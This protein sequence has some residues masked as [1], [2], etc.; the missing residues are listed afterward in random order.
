M[1][2]PAHTFKPSR[3]NA[4]SS[5][6]RFIAVLAAGIPLALVSGCSHIP[7]A[8]SAVGTLA[9]SGRIQGGQQPVTSANIQ[10]YAVG[11]TGDG[12]AATAMLKT[13]VKSDSGGNFSITSDYTC[14][15]SSQQV[16]LVVTGGNPGLSAGTNNAALAMMAGLGSCGSLS[17]STFILVDEVTTVGSIAALYPYMTSYAAVG[18]ATGDA[19]SLTAAFS[20][21]NEFTNIAVGTAP[22][23]ALP[24]GYYASSTE[25]NTLADIVASCIN[26]AGGKA[27]DNSACGNLFTLT[28]PT[29]GAAPTDTVQAILN[30]LNNPTANVTAIFN[31]GGAY[32]P[33]LPDLASAPSNWS[34]PIL[35]IPAVPTFTPMAGTYVGT[36]TV[37]INEPT[38]GATVYYTTNGS[39]PTTSSTVYTGPITVAASET[40]KAFANEGGRIS[41]GVGTAAYV[42]TAPPPAATP[43]FSPAGGAYSAA[44]TVTI[45]DA[46]TGAFIYYTTDGSIPT[47]SSPYYTG[48][49]TVY[50]T[51]T[52]QAIAVAANY[53]ASAIGS[54]SYTISLPYGL[55][56]TFA[57]TGVLG[58]NGDGIAATSAE[59]YY[60][61]TVAFDASGN[62]YIA[63]FQNN[64]VRKVTTSGIISTVAGTGTAGFSGDGGQATSATLNGPDSVAVDS[65][66]NLYIDDDYN[67]R[68]RK[69]T[70][71]GVI[72]TI[73]GTGL[74]QAGVGDGGLATSASFTYSCEVTLDSAGNV[75]LAECGA[76][77]NRV[78]KVSTAGIM[79]TYAGNGAAGSTGD[80]GAATSAELDSPQ[81][82]AFDQSGNLYISD[83]MNNK[84][85]KVTPA[86]IISTIAGTGA[87]TPYGGD[88]G[89]A[90]S[91]TLNAPSGLS[92]DAAGNI[93]FADNG[94][95]RVRKI[96]PAGIISVAAGTGVGGFSGDGALATGAELYGPSGTAF[97]P[98]GNLY[99]ADERNQRIRKV[100]YGATAPTAGTPTF[101]EPGG[102]YTAIQYVSLSSTTT[103]ASIYYTTNG[104]TPTTASTLYSGPI[105]VA[106]SETIEAIA[107]ASGVANSAVASETFIINILPSAATPAFSPAGGS[108]TSAQSV[109]ISS[110]T[111]GASIY[112]TTNGSTPTTAST[113]YTG[114]ITVSS[115][116]TISAIAVAS[117]YNT[118]AVGTA[119]YLINQGVGIITTIAGN[120]AS[121]FTGDGGAATS[122]ELYYPRGSAVDSSG[123]VY[124]A[125]TD[126]QRIRKVTPAGVISTVAGTGTA[127]FS[128]DGGLATSATLD[129][130][131]GVAVDGS[132]NLYVA[133]EYNQRIRKVSTAGIITTV[134]GNGVAT[135]AGDGGSATSASLDD[136]FGVAVDSSGN[137]YIADEYN[138]R[139]RKVSPAGV[140]TT[141]AGNGTSGY[142]GDGGSATSAELYYPG[143][144]AVDS[145]GNVYIADTDNQR[146]RKVTAAGLI[147]TIAGTGN[148]G[149]SGDGSA[150]TSATMDDPSG[151]A[152]DS[153]GNVYFS[154]TYNY[155]IRKISTAGIISTVV[156]SGSYGFSGDGGVATSAALEYAYAVT[157]DATG[158]LYVADS[159]NER[160]RKV[161]YGNGLQA[162]T[163]VL[164]LAAGAY[165]SA[166]YLVMTTATPGAAIY[167]TT[168]G[169]T[170]STSSTLYT[171]A[172]TIS[173]SETIEAIA[174]AN[175]YSNSAVASA[176]Y[177]FNIEPFA[178]SP[179]FSPAAGTFTANQT[180]TLTTT[181]TSASIYYTTNGTTP[182]AS[183]TLYTGP[184]TVSSSETISAVAVASGYNNSPVASAGYYINPGLGIITTIAGNGSTGFSGDGGAATSAE[185][186][187]PRAVAVDSAG[188]TYIADVSNNRIRKVT[189]AGIISTVAGTG[190][191][192]FSGDG[193]LATSA[194][195]EYP[196]SV[197]VDSSGNLYIA[198]EGN[199]RIRKVNTSGIIFTIAGNGTGGFAGDGGA[200][201][202]A[203]VDEPVGVAVDASGNV[204]IADYYNFRIRKINTAGVI[205]TV[206]G[207]GG[208]GFSGDGGAATS[209][210]MTYPSSVAVDAS[211]NFYFTD[212]YNQRVRKVTAAGII[213]TIAGN[214]SA[215]FTGDGGAAT[216]AELY[217]PE[218]VA[219]DS[220][221]NVY[222]ADEENE[223]IRKVTPGGTISTVVG[224]GMAG[225]AGDKGAATT[226]EIDLP[227]GVAVDSY[228]NLYIADYE[229]ERIRQVTYGVPP[230]AATPV[231]SIAAGTYPAAQSISITDA[232]V[233][234][235]IYYTTDGSI[236][237]T[238][239]PVYTGPIT[240]STTETVEAIASAPQYNTSNIA[241]AVYIIQ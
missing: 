236:P 30:I 3:L 210:T 167:Y 132:G 59:L 18:S 184:I 85:R 139:I 142:N 12:S 80:G 131:I 175:G 92:L 135:F 203:E 180:V 29:G 151:I 235:T 25:I 176:A 112:Y 159:N 63:D 21:V 229:N 66:G 72:S 34:L 37:T 109:T 101:S 5:I 55:I 27:G 195:L 31:L 200:A 172:L 165:T 116:E 98:S 42:I 102:T 238:S 114:A 192:G 95:N 193:G 60:P 57:G 174:I 104:A 227:L 77:G 150:A 96:T 39:T 24:A 99:I 199:N 119:G 110:A 231:F 117:G 239:S 124:I 122:A 232:T 9:L 88:G 20:E 79:S 46:T 205:S 148:S 15:S 208:Y 8:D 168:N 191:Y 160:L 69:V 169:T 58:Y 83:S 153:T 154:D 126:N 214:G 233:G 89:A 147:S 206:A 49:I 121:G 163:P 170:P 157:V 2:T 138:Q 194:A 212:V 225:F 197:A 228:G 123:N 164:S 41:G 19:S 181:T 23:P 209:A 213:S 113:L 74:N 202:N 155:R 216:S 62:A 145:S 220:T 120:G 222:I 50:E 86:G 146:I 130:P 152:V 54:A 183:S 144:V 137:L 16:Y 53:S 67:N 207:T 189:P 161:T 43:T 215:G 73:A 196:E 35:P 223:R 127:G 103:G 52:V 81:G 32:V 162:A 93:Y 28:T 1:S 217:Y 10:L 198:D 4:V 36:Q 94:N 13:A 51:E 7:V 115:S 182:S 6:F 234:S 171:G 38:F 48:P 78:R 133:D 76:G 221:G 111:T 186:Y 45:S 87:S 90:T 201:T 141:I 178:V 128:G 166:Q 179:T 26:S 140:I 118:S 211:G 158:N 240:V 22:G 224:N 136:P 149:F 82:L 47:T 187:Y 237:T 17:A 177:V 44:Q 143:G 65:A 219:V 33:F 230:P 204:Y 173:T 11:A 84:I 106:S 134:A 64:R 129:Y 71:A 241:S 156:G 61:Y 40:I 226:A 56:S 91:A 70:P 100:V 14:G 97:D 107:V 108:Y 185:L 68:I 188:N 75:Y 105:T 190:S 125:D 218:G